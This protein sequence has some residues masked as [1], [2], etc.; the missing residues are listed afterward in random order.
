MRRWLALLAAAT[1]SLVLF[2]LLVPL[3]LLVRTAAESGA[4]AR[5][6]G[7]A[8]SMAVAVGTA[9]A[10]G[11]VDAET[12]HLTAERAAHPTTVFLGDG[13]VLGARAE[14]SAAVELAARGRS[15]TA[16][17]PGGREILVAV[18]GAPGGTAVV[19]VLLRDDELTGGVA[20]VQAGLLVLGLALVGL[21][22]LVA[23]RLARA[24]TR[25]VSSLAGVSHRLAAGDLAARAV[26][27]GPPEVRAVGLAL[28]H[29]AERITG[30]LAEE[31]ENAADLS[32]RLRTP[33]TGLRLEAES[34]SDPDEAAR[35]EARVD[36]LERAV[37][38]VIEEARRRSRDR[39]ECDAV[40]VVGDRVAFWSVL[41]EDQGRT[42]E[43]DLCPGPRTVAVS[44][45]DLAACVDALLGNV[46]AHT[47]EETPFGVRLAPAP[48][49]ALLTVDDAGPGFG[50]A[51]PLGRGESG[52]GSTG[53]GLDIARRT[54][55]SS[56]GALDLGASPAGGARV[57]LFLAGSGP[58]AGS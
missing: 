46:F 26:P 22:M 19:R 11:T 30:L 49:G 55:E 5:A 2:A 23:D 32:H 52:A 14:R 57:T 20:R 16:A 53:L 31:R 29:L 54:A 4:V 25:P 34:L 40:A 15:V 38:A 44:A 10:A 35:V 51:D 1:T 56:G 37:T 43:L 45:G 24:M 50:T 41:A 3:L 36:A 6:S 21:G 33:L 8:E 12:L 9:G 47:D 18:Q 17:V 27:G 7:E 48:G 58:L 42:V 13:R 39:A 28:N